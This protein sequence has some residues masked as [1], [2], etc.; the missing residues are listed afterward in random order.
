MSAVRDCGHDPRVDEGSQ[1]KDIWSGHIL[2]QRGVTCQH[3]QG[4]KC[5]TGEGTVRQCWEHWI[6]VCWCRRFIKTKPDFLWDAV[7]TLPRMQ[8]RL[9]SVMAVPLSSFNEIPL[10]LSARLTELN[11]VQTN[12]IWHSC[13]IDRRRSPG[14]ATLM[15]AP[16]LPAP[17]MGS[18]NYNKQELLLLQYSGE[19]C[20]PTVSGTVL[21][22]TVLS[23]LS[24]TVI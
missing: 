21:R 18:D 13:D 10:T 19:H 22:C 2:S 23:P 1:R 4:E 15:K 24:S 12:Y 9:V 16:L 5:F 3:T 8:R 7:I 14:L 6:G 11:R 20:P 17:L